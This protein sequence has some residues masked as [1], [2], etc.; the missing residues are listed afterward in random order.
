MAVGRLLERREIMG[1]AMG[2]GVDTIPLYRQGDT[3]EESLERMRAHPTGFFTRAYRETGPVF[4]TWFGDDYRVV[5]AGLEAN[6]FAWRQSDLWSYYEAL[7]GFREQLGPD[8]VTALDGAH[9]R[10]KRFILKP[11]YDQAPI[12]RFLPAY[13]D[14]FQRELQTIAGADGVELVAFWAEAIAKANSLT[15]ARADIG[16]DQLKML[17]HWEKEL[18]RGLFLGDGRHAFYAQQEYV[19]L[20]AQGMA[21]MSRLVDER[22]AQPDNYDDGF[23]AVMRSRAEKEGG[24]PNRDNLIDDMYLILVAGVE[25]TSRL[26]NR[27][28]VSAWDDPAWLAEVRAELAGWDGTDVMALSRMTNLKA[29]IMETQRLHPLVNLTPRHPT[30]AFTF[31]GYELPE[32]VLLYH[33][34]TVGQFL[35]EIYE[36]PFAFQ[37]RRFVEKGQFVPR[38]N[39]FFGGGAHVCLGRNQTM[40][41]TPIAL[42][43][44]LKNYDLDYSADP[45]FLAA[46]RA[47]G[48]LIDEN[49][50]RL[51]PRPS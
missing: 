33:A 7:A 28:L 45:G 21:L 42:A 9:H 13:L 10:Q 26:I 11:A 47:P 22:L 19:E 38:T 12:M 30:R 46:A 14:C 16:D 3:D 24:A 25:N 43:L 2:E 18:L 48:Q 44:M 8:H 31:Q 35:E 36:E 40:L 49:R 34:N 17:V 27:A 51:R 15:L 5:I 37:P 29:T 1:T 32:G 50:V 4:R 6:D 39:G 41:Q 20:K 23:A